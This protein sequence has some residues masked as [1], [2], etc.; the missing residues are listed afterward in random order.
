MSIGKRLKEARL[1]A[2]FRSQGDLADAV[3]IKR[4]SQNRF[5]SDKQTPNGEYFVKAA[6]LGLDVAYV[7]TGLAGARDQA[8][9]E[10]LQRFRASSPDVE[11]VVLRALGI[12]TTGKKIATVAISGGEQG[13]VV[14]GDVTQKKVTFNVGTKK[15]K[16]AK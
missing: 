7:L 16:A 2:R 9:S 12:A 11:S 13:Q 3:G 1:A 8:E 15:K 10:L 5:E 6:E 14:A 4:E